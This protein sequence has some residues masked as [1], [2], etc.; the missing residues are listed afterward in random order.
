MNGLADGLAPDDAGGD[1]FDGISE[2]SFDRPFAIHWLAE[3]VHD[4]AQHGFAYGHLEQFASSANFAALRDLGVIAQ[5]DRADLGFFKI[6]READDAVAEVE[7]FIEHRVGQ[8]FD[9][10][11]AVADLADGADVLLCRSGFDPRDLGF[12]LL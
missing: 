6:Q 12:N 7:H 2:F 1:F 10:G 11:H 9:F 8:A 4:T 5:N 3:G